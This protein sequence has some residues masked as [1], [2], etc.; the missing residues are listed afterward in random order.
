M[1]LSL[2]EVEVD[3]A[4]VFAGARLEE[5]LDPGYHLHAWLS[6]SF[7]P[8]AI[9]PF[10]WMD[11]GDGSR[12]LGYSELG[13][14][15]LRAAAQRY[16]M[17][18][19]WAAIRTKSMPATWPRGLR[20]GFALRASPTVRLSG[21]VEGRAS[22]GAEVDAYLAARWKDES[23]DR[24][25]VYREWLLQ[26][27]QRHGDATLESFELT[28]HRLTRMLR[29]KQGGVRKPT[30]LTLPEMECTGVLAIGEPDRFR[31]LLARGVGRHRAFGFGML[32]LRPPC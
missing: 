9:Q 30:S 7:G 28:R 4:R 23:A 1:T 6:Q 31:E 13:E 5:G 18:G 17:P 12:L 25:A 8:G 24:G 21:G 19:A 27:I 14:A 20:V 3:A 29:R 10:H 32:L 11:R 22:K 26:Q 16:A 2:V 15:E